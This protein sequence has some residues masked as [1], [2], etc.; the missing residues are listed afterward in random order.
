LASYLLMVRAT[1]VVFK[2]LRATWF[3]SVLALAWLVF[4]IAI[5]SVRVNCVGIAAIKGGPSGIICESGPPLRS[6]TGLG[7]LLLLVFVAIIA[8]VPLVFPGRRMLFVV[9]LG[10]AAIVVAMIV[11]CLDLQRYL[12]LSRLGLSL[13]NEARSAL[14]LLL[15]VSVVWIVAAFRPGR[16]E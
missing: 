3:G 9:G 5:P 11:I 16:R 13:T 8:T 7:L 14:L 6:P 10:S 1:S 15:P 4:L 2:R 12:A